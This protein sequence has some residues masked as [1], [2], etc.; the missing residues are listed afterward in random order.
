[1]KKISFLL[2]AVLLAGCAMMSSNIRRDLSAREMVLPSVILMTQVRKAAAAQ[3]ITDVESMLA[4]FG[5]TPRGDGD[6][7]YLTASD[8]LRACG[9]CAID[10]GFGAFIASLAVRRQSSN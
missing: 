5:V 6:S 4:S 9:E 3:S 7:Q 2:A 1:M 8:L 10:D